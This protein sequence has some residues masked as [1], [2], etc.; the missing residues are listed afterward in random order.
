MTH[1]TQATFECFHCYSDGRMIA[2]TFV[3]AVRASCDVPVVT[4]IEIVQNIRD[5]LNDDGRTDFGDWVATQ[6]AK[7]I[8]APVNY[9]QQHKERS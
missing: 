2:N 7:A 9:M 3:N 5:Q 6:I 1:D 4:R 8:S